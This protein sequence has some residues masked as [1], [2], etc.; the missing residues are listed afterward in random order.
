MIT[1]HLVVDAHKGPKQIFIDFRA[2]KQVLANVDMDN[3]SFYKP[4]NV[5]KMHIG[6]MLITSELMMKFRDFE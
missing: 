2:A 6:C 1:I 5:T 3:F 4:A